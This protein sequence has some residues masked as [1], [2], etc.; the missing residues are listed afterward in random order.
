MYTELNS[1]YVN[2][3]TIWKA[4]LTDL[5]LIGSLNFHILTMKDAAET[6]V[7]NDAYL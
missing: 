7:E 5:P 1:H 2:K 3:H 6:S 4:V